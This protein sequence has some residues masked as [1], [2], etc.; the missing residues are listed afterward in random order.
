MLFHLYSNLLYNYKQW[1]FQ[2]NVCNVTVLRQVAE[3]I[4][5]QTLRDGS[6]NSQVE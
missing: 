5:L 1:M 6:I 3:P 4:C 2:V